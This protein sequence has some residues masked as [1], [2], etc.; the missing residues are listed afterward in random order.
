VIRECQVQC[1][2]DLDEDEAQRGQQTEQGGTPLPP[3]EALELFLATGTHGDHTGLYPLGP[4]SCNGKPFSQEQYTLPNRPQVA[5]S[6]L[7]GLSIGTSMTATVVDMDSTSEPDGIEVEACVEG[8]KGAAIAALA[9]VQRLELC[10]AL[11]L[12]GVTPG[13]GL[14]KVVRRTVDLPLTLLLR[15]RRGDFYY[16][17]SEFESLELDVDFAREQGAEGVALGCLTRDG[18]IDRERTARLMDRARPMEV[19]FHRAFDQT[20]DQIEALEVLAELGVERVL[21]SGGAERAVHGLERLGQLVQQAAGRLRVI[22]A[23][24]I[25][26]EN[27]GT[28]LQATGAQD[29][30]LSAGRRVVSPAWQPDQAS[31]LGA[32][33]LPGESE[34]TWTDGEILRK[35]LASLQ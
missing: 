27:S 11:A 14:C 17:T 28:I 9:G 29:L 15:P 6:A 5:R 10:S 24:G 33:E 32:P 20:R 13:P 12:G 8:P 34:L 4:Q 16:G 19:T 18:R 1:P 23:A 3:E 30:H 31:R 25:G 21:S 26:P 7:T 2:I 35:L 22:P